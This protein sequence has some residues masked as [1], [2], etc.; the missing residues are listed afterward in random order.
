MHS[1][2]PAGRR[3]W[4]GLAVLALPC[5]LYS[6]DLTVLNLAVPRLVADLAP[7]STELLW[8]I[9]IYGFVLAGSLVTMGTLGDRIGRRRLLLWGAA[10]FGAVSTLA[11]FSTSA[12]ML[13]AARAV[14]GLAGATLA[15]ST[16]SLIHVM[17]LQ[18]R[19][20]M[21]AVGVWAASFSAGSALG[22][23]LGALLLEHFR[24]GT[25]FL[26]ALPVMVVLLGAGPSL[27]PEVKAP[28]AG[29]LDW[30]SAGLSLAAVLLAIH[31]VKDL[32]RG[33][34]GWL[35]AFPAAALL[36]AVFVRRQRSLADPLLDLGMF[37]DRAFRVALATNV[38]G[39]FVAFGLYNVIAQ[40][41][42]LV[43]GLSPLQAGYWMLPTAAAFTV[44]STAV[45]AIVRRVRPSVVLA[46][47]LV[48]AGGG[49]LIMAQLA[50]L[51]GLL[52]GWVVFSLGL[53]TVPTL[54]TAMIID[55][56]PPERAGAASG[57][58]E[59]SSEL[60][61]ALGIALL[62]SLGTAVYRGHLGQGVPVEAD[63]LARA[64]AIA[65]K[66][67]ADRAAA[68]LDACRAAF[69]RSFAV[70]AV[71]GA[72]VLFAAAGI[73]AVSLR[74]QGRATSTMPAVTT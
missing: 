12:R 37:G 66:L 70:T 41:M 28:G 62:G 74:G 1:M 48:L 59:T 2:K 64:A 27:L 52:A 10:A 72:G 44:G 67:P 13:I 60:G 4:V 14:L 6:M 23:L 18:P 68:L 3:E 21:F 9:D 65:Q 25:V 36:G 45:P 63:S 8:I 29:R 71:V 20:R 40:Y 5:L 58:A 43:L 15:P 54:A 46:G 69:E 49:L 57:I 56:A 38:L 32:A 50:G 34:H 55:S 35:P 22:P 39:V 33:G 11:A 31:G 51:T 30:P 61:G 7:S 47:G 19:Q 26:L 17:F 53:A 16:L 73:V 24:W 42:Q